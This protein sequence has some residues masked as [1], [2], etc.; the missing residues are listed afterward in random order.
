MKDNNQKEVKKTTVTTK[1]LYLLTS[2]KTSNPLKFLS[3]DSDSDR[4]VI[5]T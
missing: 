2:K 1:P 5:A 3:S 4:A